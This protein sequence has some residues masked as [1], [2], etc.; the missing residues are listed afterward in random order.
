MLGC[1]DMQRFTLLAII[2]VLAFLGLA[3]SWYLA[4]AAL[5]DT[6]LSCGIEALDQCNTVAQSE[7]SR[8]FGIPLAVYGV[9]FYVL[10]F[11]FAAVMLAVTKPVLTRILYWASVIGFLASLYFLYLQ[12]FVIKALCVYCLASFALSVLLFLI[13]WRLKTREFVISH[14]VIP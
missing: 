9:A 10:F 4:Q 7:Y 8:L 5:S 3:D 11:V 6:A 2:L 14:S 12:V 13:V 1:G